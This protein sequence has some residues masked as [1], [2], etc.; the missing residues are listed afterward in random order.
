MLVATRLIQF[1]GSSLKPWLNFLLSI[2]VYCCHS[3]TCRHGAAI[4]EQIQPSDLTVKT[5]ITTPS[6]M[7]WQD[8][9][10]SC[11]LCREVKIQWKQSWE[12]KEVKSKPGLKRLSNPI[13]WGCCFNPSLC[14]QTKNSN[15]N[16]SE[17][18]LDFKKV[19][20]LHAYCPATKS[21]KT[22]LPEFR[23]YLT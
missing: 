1:T 23:L 11:H 13:H 12:V 6:G 9:Y 15:W 3:F 22:I 19:L 5:T 10:H 14:S 20:R 21:E 8:S 2:L 16:V 4:K 17:M 7:L 18:E